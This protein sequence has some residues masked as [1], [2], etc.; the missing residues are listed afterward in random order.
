MSS[1][2]KYIPIGQE[3]RSLSD[4][5]PTDEEFSDLKE[6]VNTIQD[7]DQD[8]GRTVQGLP[9]SEMILVWFYI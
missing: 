7:E 5:I 9:V 6:E 8:T 2:A 3:R 1:N 4:P